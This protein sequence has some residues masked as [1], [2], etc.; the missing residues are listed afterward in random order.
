[1]DI[2]NKLELNKFS[3][4]VLPEYIYKILNELNINLVELKDSIKMFE[5]VSNNDSEDTS[6]YNELK[7]KI[8][9]FLG[10][11]DV[12]EL[13][14]LNKYLHNY[15]NVEMYENNFSTYY[16][17]ILWESNKNEETTVCLI[18][19]TLLSNNINEM[20]FQ[21]TYKVVNINGVI[22]VL[23]KTGFTNFITG[24]NSV[25]TKKTLLKDIIESNNDE[26]M[27]RNSL[28]VSYI[29]LAYI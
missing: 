12:S 27:V 8:T 24:I 26:A 4:M 16:K 3:V 17:E 29:K 10:K 28:G 6:G 25:Q 20:K 23:I 14:Y 21:D 9:K 19:N 13:A 11:G 22:L 18:L 1:M 15:L 7:S 2:N 5:D